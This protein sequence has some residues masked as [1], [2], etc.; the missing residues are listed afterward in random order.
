MINQNGFSIV[1][2]LSAQST[3]PFALTWMYAMVA[4]FDVV[5]AVKAPECYIGY[6]RTVSIQVID[7]IAN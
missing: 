3:L 4:G 1:T 6:A 5:T 7:Y 2:F